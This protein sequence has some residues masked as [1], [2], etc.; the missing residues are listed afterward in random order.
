MRA[1]VIVLN[2]EFIPGFKALF[3]SIK[4]NTP[5]F[6]EDVICIS[7][8]LVE[9]EKEE[10][11]K[12]YDR[13][14]FTEP[15][16]DNYQKLPQS[17]AALKNAF[18]KLEVFRLAQDYEHLLFMDCDIIC[19]SSIHHLINRKPKSELMI[20]H[21]A[22]GRFNSGVMVLNKLKP[23]KYEG[24]IKILREVKEAHLGDQSIIEFAAKKRLISVEELARKWNTTKRNV[25]WGCKGYHVIHFVGRKPWCGG[26]KGYEKIEKIWFE[27]SSSKLS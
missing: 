20:V 10:C 13:I 16:W 6:S 1:F 2:K 18:Y 11:L 19:I 9:K 12:T 3:N 5:E 15:I 23:E 17:A 4:R 24:I 25:L 22:A 8:D 7:L 21:E 14:T 27:Y 26:E